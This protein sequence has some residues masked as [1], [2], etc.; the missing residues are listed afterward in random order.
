MKR[1]TCLI[2][3]TLLLLCSCKGSN[4]KKYTKTK[5]LM[6]TVVTITAYGGS[7]EILDGAFSLCEKY[8][9]MF[10]RTVMGSDVSKLNLNGTADI[11]PDTL[12]LITI[13]LNIS[14]KSGGAFDMTVLP[15]SVLWDV[16][17]A[18]LPPSADSIKSALK[19]VN[20]KN[21][22]V[23][24]NTVKL[25]NGAEIDLGG[26]AKGYIADRVKEYLLENGIKKAIINLGGNV[27]LLGENEQFTVGIQKPFF[28]NGTVKLKLSLDDKTAVTSG[29]YERYFEHDG[30]IYHHV[31][32]PKTG[33]P[34]QNELTSVTIICSSSAIADGLST[35]CLVL[36]EEKGL[37]L[38]KQY[39]AEAVFIKKDGSFTLS[40][41]LL[42]TENGKTPVIALK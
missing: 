22:S 4:E 12:E 19:S 31:I 16:E 30:N 6:T 24:D 29:I 32:D 2:I 5:V 7:E 37:S 33:Y 9:Q 38:I 3:V 17:N 23:K 20:Y 41:G 39:G 25:I 8:E 27:M 28:E 36:G 21:C 35:A 34:S 10:S 13:G 18:T 15:L 11:S 42:V 14:E 26:I 1:I 40:D